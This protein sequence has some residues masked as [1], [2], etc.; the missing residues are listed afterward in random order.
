MSVFFYGVSEMIKS[1]L[2]DKMNVGS[3]PSLNDTYSKNNFNS[4][5]VRLHFPANHSSMVVAVI[6]LPEI[7]V[8]D[9]ANNTQSCWLNVPFCAILCIKVRRICSSV[10]TTISKR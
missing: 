10:N 6:G 1:P 2:C 3:L 8:T 7:K 9:L 5:L 4:L